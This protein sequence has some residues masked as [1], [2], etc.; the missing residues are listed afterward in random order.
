MTSKFDTNPHSYSAIIF[1][2]CSILLFLG[3]IGLFIWL[4]MDASE[5]NMVKNILYG[6]AFVAI[7]LG[8]LI[9]SLCAY[10]APRTAAGVLWAAMALGVA[11]FIVGLCL[12]TPERPTIVYDRT[13]PVHELVRMMNID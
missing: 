2:V 5:D 6:V 9:Y 1:L 4:L 11:T 3:A 10:K 12:K 8:V 7:T 13:V